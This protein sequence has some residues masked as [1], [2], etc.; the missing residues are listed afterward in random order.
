MTQKEIGAAA[1][2]PRRA[3][4]SKAYMQAQR[5][6]YTL[7]NYPV[8]QHGRR[9]VA[10]LEQAGL[11]YEQREVALHE[12][13]HLAPWYL[14]INPNHQ[15]PALVDAELVLSES[16]AIL[17]YLCEVNGL[18]QWYPRGPQARA[19]VDQWLD[20]NQCRLGSV[21]VDI[22]LNSVFMGERGDQAAIARGRERLP[23]LLERIGDALEG[24]SYLVGEAPTIADLSLFSNIAHLGFADIHPQRA[25]TQAWYARVAE[26]PGVARSQPPT[27]N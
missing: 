17:R 14:A 18:E 26:L 3:L 22:V 6:A 10:L 25:S 16:N 23:E 20:W 27:P 19:Q 7:Y 4:V 24:R 1:V 2:T 11:P 15:V 8:S 12:G 13:Q 21:V 5:S 9:V